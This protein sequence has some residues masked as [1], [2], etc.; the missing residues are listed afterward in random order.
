MFKTPPTF[1][2]YAIEKKASAVVNA[3]AVDAFVKLWIASKKQT[4]SV[5]SAK[6]LNILADKVTDCGGQSEQ[7]NHLRETT[8][9]AGS[10]YFHWSSVLICSLGK[11]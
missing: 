2:C 4:L 1:I 9:W 5:F 10:L 8:G 6:S 7:S 3:V 11:Y